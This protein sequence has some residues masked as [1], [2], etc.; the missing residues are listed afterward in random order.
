MNTIYSVGNYQ[1]FNLLIVDIEVMRIG[2]RITAVTSKFYITPSCDITRIISFREG[3]AIRESTTSNALY[4]FGDGDGG[5]GG[6][7]IE[8][9]ISNACDAVGDA[10]VG[11]GFGDND[12]ARVFVIAAV[13]T[14]PVGYFHVVAVKVVVIDTIDGKIFSPKACCC[15]EGKEKKEKFSHNC[16]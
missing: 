16:M 7:F 11:D 4:A 15:H 9:P 3:R 8:S 2:N 6:A 12:F 10:V 5:E 13:R 14:S 1:V